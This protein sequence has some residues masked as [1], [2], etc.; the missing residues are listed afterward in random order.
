MV[1]PKVRTRVALLATACV[2][3]LT[4]PGVHAVHIAEA[5][6]LH[7]TMSEIALDPRRRVLRIMIRVFAGD[8]ARAVAL[9]PSSR[10]TRDSAAA[11]LAYVRG[12][13]VLSSGGR[14]LPLRSCGTRRAGDVRWVCME[15]D[16][17]SSVAALRL[18]NT[19]LMALFTD[20]VNIVRSMV[21]GTPRSV[22]Y[23]RGDGAKALP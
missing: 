9:A 15:A 1:T 7:T 21:S 10:S 19:L 16:A 20:Q 12:S 14:P 2:A 4:W 23:T 8:F 22:M 18:E 3:A 13:V 17:P 5:H 11:E 6:P